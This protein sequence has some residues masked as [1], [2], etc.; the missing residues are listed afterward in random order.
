MIC[1]SLHVCMRS[2]TSTPPCVRRRLT[3][4][5]YVEMGW[6]P[7]DIKLKTK[8]KDE[9]WS[10]D[11]GFPVAM[12]GWMLSLFAPFVISM[13]EAHSRSVC[14]TN[15]LVEEWRALLFRRTSMH[16]KLLD[17][18]LANQC[19]VATNGVDVVGV[20]SLHFASSAA[21]ILFEFFSLRRFRSFE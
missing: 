17:H 16:G 1:A 5:K 4:S 3:S 14:S 12:R 8:S 6:W 18:S 15:K 20:H 9:D 21:T 13:S 11:K 2:K 10:W 19:L 7:Y